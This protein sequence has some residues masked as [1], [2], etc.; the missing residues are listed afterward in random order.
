MRYFNKVFFIIAGLV[1]IQ[2]AEVS[3][4]SELNRIV[5]L[6]PHTTELVFELGMGDKLVAV[7]D[8]SDYPAEATQLPSVADYNGADFEAIVRSEPDLI[9]VWK[10]G[11]KP[12]DISRLSKLGYRLF[13]SSPD[14]VWDIAKEIKELGKL[15]GTEQRAN[16]V[17]EQYLSSLKAIQTRYKNQKQTSVFYYMWPK[18]LMSIG[19]GAWANHLL[20]LCGATNVFNNVISDYPEVIIEDVLRRKPEIM[21]AAMKTALNEAEK[22]WEKYNSLHESRVVVVDPDRL[23]RFTPRILDGLDDLCRK[24]N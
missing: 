11:N 13:Y 8:Y 3:A 21:I 20:E 17:S 7:S 18:P 2:C 12:Q 15:L 23:H 16:L 4:N 14:S 6:A 22:Q 9:L 24:I 1:Y 19:K 10:G 5:S